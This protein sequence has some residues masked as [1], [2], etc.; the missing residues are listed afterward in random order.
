MLSSE[1]PEEMTVKEVAKAL[2]V[3]YMTVLRWI[4]DEWLEAFKR[5]GQWR[6]RR[7]EFERFRREGNRPKKEEEKEGGEFI[8]GTID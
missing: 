4:G 7:E 8:E 5:G 1:L 3:R 6:I 2:G